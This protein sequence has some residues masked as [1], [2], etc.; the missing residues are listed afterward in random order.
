MEYA[1]KHYDGVPVVDHEMPDDTYRVWSRNFAMRL[2]AGIS[3]F[4]IWVL[5]AHATTLLYQ[6]FDDLVTKAEAIVIG[7]VYS[8]ESLYDQNREIYTFV[9]LGELEI[10]KGTYPQPTLVIR[11]EGG[12]IGE[13]TQKV[14]GSPWF[15]VN[16]RPLLFIQGN[17]QYMVPFV[18]WTQGVF[19]VRVEEITGRTTIYDYEGNPV[20]EDMGS[21]L[22]IARQHVSEAQVLRDPFRSASS[23][24]IGEGSRDQV[25]QGSSSMKSLERLSDIPDEAPAA[26]FP[27]PFE[28]TGQAALEP[29][30]LEA[31]R[32]SIARRLVPGKLNATQAE[33]GKALRSASIVEFRQFGI[34]QGERRAMPPPKEIQRELGL[35]ENGGELGESYPSLPHGDFPPSNLAEKE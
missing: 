3:L 30:S 31:F 28:A 18:G 27:L 2:L 24:V 1:M 5:P 12:I 33:E 32:E 25:P 29:M 22:L 9:T 17:G 13:T 7:T 20:L 8:V 14:I 19:Q 4:F 6:S 11:M 15:H 23:G 10:L 21:H 26:E 34:T 16:D 35:P